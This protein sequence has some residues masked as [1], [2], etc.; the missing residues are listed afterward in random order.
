[1]KHVMNIYGNVQKPSGARGFQKTRF[2]RGGDL[3]R[4]N[5][6]LKGPSRY[7]NSSFEHD[8]NRNDYAEVREGPRIRQNLDQVSKSLNMVTSRLHLGSA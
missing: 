3:T 8:R 1:M 4:Q 6:S 2:Y 7:L 5:N